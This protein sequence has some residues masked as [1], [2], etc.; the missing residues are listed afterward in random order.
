MPITGTNESKTGTTITWDEYF[1]TWDESTGTWD[2][3]GIAFNN[4]PQNAVT[5]SNESQNTAVSATNEVQN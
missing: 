3:P 2:S 5:A 1:D 4:D